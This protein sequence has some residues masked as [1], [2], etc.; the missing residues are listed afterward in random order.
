MN[1]K[2][3]SAYLGFTVLYKCYLAKWSC[4]EAL[5]K[6]F[7]IFFLTNLDSN[8]C[9]V[10]KIQKTEKG[11]QEIK[12]AENLFR[13]FILFHSSCLGSFHRL[14]HIITSTQTKNTLSHLILKLLNF[15]FIL[16][17]AALLIFFVSE[18]ESVQVAGIFQ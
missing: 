5:F 2:L 14:L 18:A 8:T 6:S 9:S 4:H 12:I 1:C 17:L 16:L 3:G 7:Q 11:T 13:S 10:Q 15:T